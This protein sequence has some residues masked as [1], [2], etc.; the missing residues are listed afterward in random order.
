MLPE[1]VVE[2]SWDDAEPLI[3]PEKLVRQHL[4][5]IPLI[6]GI[7][8]PFTKAPARLTPDDLKAYIVEAAG[9][10]ALETGLN[11]FPKQHTERHAY[12]RPA[13]NGSFGHIVLRN[14][15]V[16]SIQALSV[17]T[18]DGVDIWSVP[19]AWIDTG[20][21]HQGQINIVALAISGQSGTVIP[22]AGSGNAL[23]PSL[24]GSHW[25]PGFWMVKYTTG[26]KDG[27]VPRVVNQLIG[28]IAAMEVLSQLATT[29]SRTSSS[30]LGIDGFS[31]SVSTPGPELFNL[32]MQELGAKRKWL[33]NKLKKSFGLGIFAD[34]V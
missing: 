1:N 2:T 17:T 6:S 26:F 8:D 5:G 29:F 3:T 4:W 34:N 25:V 20:Y 21:L 24:M 13:Q 14:R 11:F 23:M 33:V 7:K 10:A 16:S 12:D 30:S 27:V 28:C 31:Q 22:F 18:T 15:P 9:L 19:T 32:R